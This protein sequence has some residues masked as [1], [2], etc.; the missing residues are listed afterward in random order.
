VTN[1]ISKLQLSQET[2]RILTKPQNVS[3][4]LATTIP[5]CPTITTDPTTGP[6]N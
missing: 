2:L 1:T 4:L 3:P 5:G 6:A